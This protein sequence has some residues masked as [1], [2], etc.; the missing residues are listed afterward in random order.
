MYVPSISRIGETTGSFVSPS[1]INHPLTVNSSHSEPPE[2]PL[3]FIP[4]KSSAHSV[5]SPMTIGL[6]FMMVVLHVSSNS[7]P[8]KNNTSD[9]VKTLS[10]IGDMAVPQTP[11]RHK[12]SVI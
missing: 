11:S 10:C 2:I 7:S 4:N 3:I 8:L 6:A 12:I 5:P 9:S 1:Y